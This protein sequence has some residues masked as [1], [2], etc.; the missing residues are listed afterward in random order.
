M[1]LKE[2]QDGRQ[3]VL[4]QFFK[5]SQYSRSE[6]HLSVA[7]LVLVIIQLQSLEDLGRS[8]LSFH[9]ALWDSI[10]GK[11]GVSESRQRIVSERDWCNL[12]SC[13]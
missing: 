3:T 10:G 5:H 2:G 8:F 12:G 13:I 9:K 4:S 6:E 7:Q 1:S 11:D